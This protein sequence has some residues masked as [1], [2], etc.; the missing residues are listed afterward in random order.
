MEHDAVALHDVATP[1]ELAQLASI[2][3]VGGRRSE[4]TRQQ[5]LEERVIDER[6][7]RVGLRLLART[8]EVKAILHGHTHDN[9]DRRVAGVRI[10]GTRDATVHG[11]S[12]LLSYKQYS[13]YPDS[14]I[15][16]ATMGIRVSEEEEFEG[17]DIGEHGL[18][19]YPNFQPL[20]ER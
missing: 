1:D 20:A 18:E 4:P 10:I 8:F 5:F 2:D 16:K 17:L 15:L 7:D 19:A 11:G 6:V 13:Y 3:A 12:G 9:L 14:G